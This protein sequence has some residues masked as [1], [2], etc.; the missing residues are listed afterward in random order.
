LVGFKSLD[1][2]SCPPCQEFKVRIGA[3][4]PPNLSKDQNNK[5]IIRA[6]S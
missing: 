6:G 3:L 1:E 2:S 5:N 4:E